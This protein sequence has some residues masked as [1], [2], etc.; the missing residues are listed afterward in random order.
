MVF[1]YM[2]V[3]VS[4]TQKHIQ[5]ISLLVEIM[6]KNY[7][8]RIKV[9][10]FSKLNARTRVNGSVKETILIRAQLVEFL[11]YVSNHSE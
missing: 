4:K 9:G 2:F 8:V 6:K 7:D 1:C 10:M 5:V 11:I 3:K